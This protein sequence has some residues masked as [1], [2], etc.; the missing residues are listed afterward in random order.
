[1]KNLM[2]KMDASRP[3]TGFA[4]SYIGDTSTAGAKDEY[5]RKVS[6]LI[7]GTAQT[8][9]SKQQDLLKQI[10]GWFSTGES[11]RYGT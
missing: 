3:K 7:A 6:D 1:M 5:G 8:R 9:T 10:Q 11:M 2:T 4:G